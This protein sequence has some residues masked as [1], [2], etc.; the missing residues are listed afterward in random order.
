MLKFSSCLHLSWSTTCHFSPKGDCCW[1]I[2]FSFKSIKLWSCRVSGL[3]WWLCFLCSWETQVP[4]QSMVFFQMV[5]PTGGKWKSAHGRGWSYLA[6][7]FEKK[8]VEGK[9]QAEGKR[10][11]ERGC[12]ETHLWQQISDFSVSDVSRFCMMMLSC[13]KVLSYQ[14]D[15]I[16]LSGHILMVMWFNS[17]SRH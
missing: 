16:V 7:A 12:L 17:S 14:K 5:C 6:T 9:T 10:Q 15:H 8:S 2:L 13:S 11:S 3:W 1:S 4:W